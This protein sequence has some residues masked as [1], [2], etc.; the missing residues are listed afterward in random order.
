MLDPLLRLLPVLRRL[1]GSLLL[2]V[3]RRPRFAPTAGP[4]DSAASASSSSS[5]KSEDSSP[6]AATAESLPPAARAAARAAD[7]TVLSNKRKMVTH[8]S[9]IWRS[10]FDRA[11]SASRYA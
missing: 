10:V 11:T 3:L 7:R 4:A 9:L 2:R 6:A 8:P 1:A 5:S